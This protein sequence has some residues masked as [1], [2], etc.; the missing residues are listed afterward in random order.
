M[1]HKKQFRKALYQIE[2][3]FPQYQTLTTH[4]HVLYIIKAQ[5]ILKI[6]S[7]KLR[8]HP[9]ELLIEKSRQNF[10]IQFWFNQLYLLLE[11]LVLLLRPSLNANI[12]LNDESTFEYV[13][14][15]VQLHFD[16][17]YQL[18]KYAFHIKQFPQ[19]FCYF[20]MI[21]NIKYFYNYCKHPRTLSIISRLYLLRANML[22]GNNDYDNSLKYQRISMNICFRGLF[23]LVDFDDGLTDDT[24]NHI[25]NHHHNRSPLFTKFMNDNFI[26]LVV[27]FYLRGVCYEH[28]GNLSKA[29]E[30]YKQ[31]KWF[32]WKFLQKDE[33][34]LTVFFMLLRERAFVYYDIVMAIK[35]V[36]EQRKKERKQKEEMKRLQLMQESSYHNV[37][38]DELFNKIKYSD[39]NNNSIH[40][41]KR[42]FN[43]LEKILSN[44]KFN[45]ID[46]IDGYNKKNKPKTTFIMST[47]KIINTLLKREFRDIVNNMNKIEINKLEGNHYDQIRKKII[48]LNYDN[49]NHIINNNNNNNTS[50]HNIK[51]ISNI[52]RSCSNPRNKI[53]NKSFVTPSLKYL[54]N[55]VVKLKYDDD[56]FCKSYLN[57]KKYLEKYNKK[58]SDFL[59]QILKLKRTE[60]EHKQ[61]FPNPTQIK[62][63]AEQD[64]AVKLFLAQS[65]ETT[66]ALNKLLTLNQTTINQYIP[67]K[68]H[69]Y[70]KVKKL[71]KSLSTSSYIDLSNSSIVSKMNNDMIRKLSKEYDELTQKGKVYEYNNN[72]THKRAK[73]KKVI[74][75]NKKR[76]G[77]LINNDFYYK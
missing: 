77:L 42:D 24:S 41:K 30:S 47:I 76:S 23:L 69:Q 4:L 11:Q 9:H 14:Q 37:N 27:S 61:T 25:H 15:I 44:I 58:E 22:I 35:K 10:S 56:I 28:L 66:N 72:N 60:S 18:A 67:T 6:I 45:T 13:E 50:M 29:I 55:K 52:N 1:L 19:L 33:K 16:M 48:E 63:D 64:F 21:D 17:I 68:Q 20:G 40:N 2:S 46:E 34:E 49:H 26:D 32:S 31:C 43:K 39:N 3:S 12:N 62:K 8:D 36:N 70:D 7:K 74:S 65:Q 57:K 38:N 51:H 5:C 71:S 75:L 59:K 54:P 53:L 73:S